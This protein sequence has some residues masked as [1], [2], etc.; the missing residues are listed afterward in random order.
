MDLANNNWKI[1]Q[2]K[3]MDNLDPDNY[4][5]YITMKIINTL[6]V[7][8]QHINVYNQDNSEK[9]FVDVYLHVLF[10]YMDYIQQWLENGIVND[11]YNE[12]FIFRANDQNYCD[13]QFKLDWNRDF[14]TRNINHYN[15]KYEALV[16]SL[17][18]PNLEQILHAGKSSL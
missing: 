8:Q 7:L 17:F 10:D 18:V 5:S 9:W 16:P 4:N 15:G 14:L 2:K 13:N 6:D 3:S 1:L 11:P 12:F